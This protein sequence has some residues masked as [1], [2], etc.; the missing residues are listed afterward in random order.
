MQHTFILQTNK[1]LHFSK[2]NPPPSINKEAEERQPIIR[3]DM[4]FH[5]YSPKVLSP[6]LS[7][8]SMI[9]NYVCIRSTLSCRICFIYGWKL[10]PEL[11]ERSPVISALSMARN[12]ILCLH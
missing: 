10:L 12:Y 1:S 3:A 6:V 7:A 8:L 11:G 9:R 2:I 5:C 4:L